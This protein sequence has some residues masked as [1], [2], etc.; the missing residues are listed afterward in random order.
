MSDI[1][2]SEATTQ[3]RLKLAVGK[4]TAVLLAKWQRG[5]KLGAGREKSSAGKGRG[6]K[7][8]IGLPHEE[9]ASLPGLPSLPSDS[10][11]LERGTIDLKCLPIGKTRR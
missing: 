2:N 3:N 11:P 4:L 5:A 1:V 7:S 6:N 10:Y 9:F 8:G